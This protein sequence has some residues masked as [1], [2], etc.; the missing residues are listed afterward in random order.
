[1]WH[2]AWLK[3][4]VS[5]HFS[6][7]YHRPKTFS[8]GDSNLP[9]GECVGERSACL[10]PD[11]HT[12]WQPDQGSSGP[13]SY[14]VTGIGSRKKK[15]KI[16]YLLMLRRFSCSARF[17]NKALVRFL[18]L[19]IQDLFLLN[20]HLQH[21]PMSIFLI[22]CFTATSSHQRMNKAAAHGSE[23]H[24]HRLVPKTNRVLGQPPFRFCCFATRIR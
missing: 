24:D 9:P 6:V 12:D 21:S 7:S 20:V 3:L 13:A 1:M 8:L 15:K 4:K 17:T 2:Q 23:Q 5:C 19:Q 14:Q 22:F 10:L 16:D 11:W 18:L